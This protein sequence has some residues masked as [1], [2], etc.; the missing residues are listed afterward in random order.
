VKCHNKVYWP[1]HLVIAAC[2]ALP[3]SVALCGAIAGI[4]PASPGSIAGYCDQTEAIEP[5]VARAL[6][7]AAGSD[8]G[9]ERT[10]PGRD[11]L[12]SWLFPFQSTHCSGYLLVCLLFCPLVCTKQRSGITEEDYQVLCAYSSIHKCELLLSVY[13]H[14]RSGTSVEELILITYLW[15][16]GFDLKGGVSR[17]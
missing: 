7:H 10:F 16:D 11:N 15:R 9:Y 4:A 8:D 12:V 17:V 2:D 1:A 13:L 3:T 14:A 6:P 5:V